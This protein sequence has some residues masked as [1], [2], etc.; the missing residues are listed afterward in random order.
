FEAATVLD[1]SIG[2]L[3]IA[4]HPR[5]F[6]MPNQVLSP[7][8]LD[9]PEIG[10]VSASLKVRYLEPIKGSGAGLR[11]GCEFVDLG[12]AALRAVQRYVNRLEAQ[13]DGSCRA[14]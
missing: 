7:C 10:Q 1:I 12:G 8:Y 6:E 14:A 11:C 2:G 3:A 4:A 5:Q 13:S 9:L